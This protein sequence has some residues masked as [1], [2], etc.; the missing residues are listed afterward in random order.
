MQHRKWLKLDEL[1]EPGM[2]RVLE[3][4]KV[5]D[6]EAP[7]IVGDAS[8]AAANLIRNGRESDRVAA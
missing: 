7:D 3:A 6:K 5:I 1:R 8:F 4:M 2:R